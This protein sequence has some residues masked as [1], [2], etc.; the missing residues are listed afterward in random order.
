[1]PAG[2]RALER[3]LT[4]RRG[5][6]GNH[7]PA[8]RPPRRPQAAPSAETS[9]RDVASY[10]AGAPASPQR[11]GRPAWP[12][13]SFEVSLEQKTRTSELTGDRGAHLRDAE[14]IWSSRATAPLV[15]RRSCPFS[16]APTGHLKGAEADAWTPLGCRGPAT[17][18]LGRPVPSEG[19]RPAPRGSQLLRERAS[20]GAHG[21]AAQAGRGRERPRA[22]RS[23][24]PRRAR[25]GLRVRM[26]KGEAASG[27][28]AVPA[29]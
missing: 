6:D 22:D 14:S 18:P 23:A 7:S 11:G 9:W 20:E 5:E 24:G 2:R 25:A 8:P 19:R 10:P 17:R 28:R 26:L 4:G 16:P 1:M 13:P 15:V 29:S 27:W 21:E 3:G 12:G